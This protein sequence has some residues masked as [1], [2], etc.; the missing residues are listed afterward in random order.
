VRF[1]L[2]K[3]RPGAPLITRQMVDEAEAQ[4]LKEEAEHH[5]KLMRR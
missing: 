5:A 3:A 4:M 2:I 1:P